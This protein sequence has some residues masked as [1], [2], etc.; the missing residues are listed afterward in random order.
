MNTQRLTEI[1]E[2]ALTKSYFKGVD[3]QVVTFEYLVQLWNVI[4]T[5]TVAI[6]PL[7]YRCE[8]AHE[9]YGP[10]QG[11]TVENAKIKFSIAAKK[12]NAANPEKDIIDLK[13]RESDIIVSDNYIQ[14]TSGVQMVKDGYIE[15]YTSKDA[16]MRQVADVISMYTSYS[17]K[18][19]TITTVFTPEVCNA[20]RIP[21]LDLVAER[22]SLK[23]FV[24]D[25]LEARQMILF[26]M[27]N[28]KVL[29]FMW[30]YYLQK[31]LHH[32]SMKPYRRDANQVQI[33]WYEKQTL[34]HKHYRFPKY[35]M[36][37]SYKVT[38]FNMS[39]EKTWVYALRS[40]ALRGIQ[41]KRGMFTSGYY[42][43]PIP[44]HY[45]RWISE[46]RDILTVC[47]DRDI[48]VIE[49]YD[50][51]RMLIDIL[52]H[53]GLAVVC[54]AISVA[55]PVHDEKGKVKPGVYGKYKGV[56]SIYRPIATRPTLDKKTV[57][58]EKIVPPSDGEI[59][60]VYLTAVLPYCALYPSTRVADGIA[61]MYYSAVEHANPSPPQQQKFSCRVMELGARFCK[62]VTWRNLYVFTRV[63]YY[64]R[65]PFV[66]EFVPYIKF[67]RLKEVKE[68]DMF[69]N[70]EIVTIDMKPAEITDKELGEVAKMK[71][72]ARSFNV[73]DEIEDGVIDILK[74]RIGIPEEESAWVLHH[75]IYQALSGSSRA[76]LV[77]L[78]II[79]NNPKYFWRV[80]K[81]IELKE[82]HAYEIDKD[83]KK[84]FFDYK[85]WLEDKESGYIMMEHV[86]YES[87]SEDEDQDDDQQEAEEEDDERESAGEPEDEKVDED[88]NDDEIFGNE[89]EID[90]TK[91]K[92]G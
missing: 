75:R 65:D 5:T 67:P 92:I 62:S 58:F 32:D 59:R 35:Y 13:R 63:P 83:P 27:Q 48:S 81:H 28:N 12:Y 69:D 16:A 7:Q 61:M 72:D 89:I 34:I 77:V 64:I 87:C 14:T 82:A 10:M 74:S 53:N 79:G 52:V 47:K 3:P 80:M 68:E 37:C 73:D 1:D 25:A 36:F 24:V 51:N 54:K 31:I 90:A 42:S 55:T 43:F 23:V 11:I 4:R 57:K 41:K 66:Q 70:K 8:E 39:L 6:T 76:H 40:D 15:D 49:M 45:T 2:S 33:S 30:F 46:A 44:A 50:A 18:Q 56:K 29:P 91:D 78:D 21:Y 84:I 9:Q 22:Q 17:T 85:R 86:D 19:K 60:S 20:V 88:D 71:V 38:L 26:K